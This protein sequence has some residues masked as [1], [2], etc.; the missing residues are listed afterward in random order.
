MTKQLK[1]L[2]TGIFL[3]L[4][5]TALVVMMSGRKE[6]GPSHS[7]GPGA[8]VA[9]QQMK[10]LGRTVT[11]AVPKVIKAKREVVAD[12]LENKTAVSQAQ[13]DLVTKREEAR[14]RREEMLDVRAQTIKELGPGNTGDE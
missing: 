4:L 2:L 7:S 14:I 1:F 11:Q 8:K 13:I 6:F 5:L 9:D 12:P 3:L 10:D